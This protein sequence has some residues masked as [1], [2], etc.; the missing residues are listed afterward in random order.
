MY[1]EA[2]EVSL[3]NHMILENN[4]ST[5]KI[6]VRGYRSTHSSQYL[7]FTSERE[8]T[9]VSLKH[10]CE[11][12]IRTRDL[13]LPKQ[14]ALTWIFTHLKLCLTDAIH[15]FKWVK[16]IQIWHNGGQLFSNIADWCHILSLT[17]LKVV[18]FC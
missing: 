12:G 16:N 7:I 1:I 13:R 18:L 3:Y 11:S 10:A 17:C 15:N 4:Y 14:A 9:F 6:K 8:E 2:E 5:K